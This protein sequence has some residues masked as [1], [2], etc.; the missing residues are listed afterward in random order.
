MDPNPRSSR[1][2]VIDVLATYPTPARAHDAFVGI[3][4]DVVAPYPGE[5]NI[6]SLGSKSL[7]D[8][9]EAAYY[10]FTDRSGVPLDNYIE[11]F[12]LGLT[13]V[14]VITVDIA[15]SG[16]SIN[17]VSYAATILRRMQGR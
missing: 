8:E 1:L 16:S 17:A 4:A 6:A 14:H 9:D 2:L 12:R 7:G 10:L 5:T 11:T 13:V 3:T 15:P